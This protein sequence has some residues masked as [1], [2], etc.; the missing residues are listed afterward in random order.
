MRGYSRVAAVPPLDRLRPAC[1]ALL[2]LAACGADGI[3]D[4][5][6]QA[7][8]DA[9]WTRNGFEQCEAGCADSAALSDAGPA[10]DA[11]TLGGTAF[12]CA[13]TH[14]FAGVMGCCASVKPRLRFAECNPAAPAPDA[15]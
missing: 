8:C 3:P 11:T 5:H 14:V 7:T 10:C 1:L 6:A 13:A 15:P 12:A 2:A 9:V 4:P